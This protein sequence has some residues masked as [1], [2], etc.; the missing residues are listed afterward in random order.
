[1]PCLVSVYWAIPQYYYGFAGILMFW[2]RECLLHENFWTYHCV[3]GMIRTGG[4]SPVRFL[5][6]ASAC[7][8]STSCF[9]PTMHTIVSVCHARTSCFT[10]TTHTMAY[11]QHP[12]AL[13]TLPHQVTIPSDSPFKPSTNPPQLLSDV[14]VVAILR[15]K[16]SIGLSNRCSNGYPVY[17]PFLT[18]N[19]THDP[20]LRVTKIN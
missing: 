3:L 16:P 9:T 7:H 4:N 12:S 10:P 2:V 17:Y 15:K 19:I 6:H 20:L 13:L 8:T 1:M 14:V 11:M 5:V 18:L